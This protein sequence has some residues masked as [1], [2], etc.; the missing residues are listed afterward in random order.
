MNRI[1]FINVLLISLLLFSC[2]KDNTPPNANETVP[3]GTVIVSGI[4]A[5]NVHTTSGAVKITMSTDGKKYL[6]FE[7]FRTDNGPDL[8]V[9]LSPS[10]SG[11]PYQEI[12]MLK[13][14]T[15]NFS[16]ELAASVNYTTNNRVLIWCKP[17]SVL[18][19][20]AVLQ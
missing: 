9:W 7:N 11:T 17:F 1:F 15:G 4:F 12:G 20:N 8:W 19:G 2:N 6:V 16:Y 18:F 5:S 13:A 3:A 10:T 14:V